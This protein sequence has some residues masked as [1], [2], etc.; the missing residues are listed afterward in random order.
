MAPFDKFAYLVATEQKD[1]SLGVLLDS[2]DGVGG[3]AGHADQE[4]YDV[5]RRPLQSG[6]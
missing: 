2:F 4:P 5:R 6:E 1:G 3:E